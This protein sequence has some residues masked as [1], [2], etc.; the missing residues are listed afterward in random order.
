MKPRTQLY[1]EDVVEGSEIPTGFSLKITWT[2]IAKNV[3]GSQDFYA[4]HHDPDFARAHGHRDPFVMRGF[5]NGCFNRL[6]HDWMGDEGFLRKFHMEF[7]KSNYLA[8]TITL[9]GKV[10]R[11]HMDNSDH[12]V[13][14][15][16]WCENEKDG[17]TT[18]CKCTVVLPSRDC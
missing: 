10:T 11:K 6:I 13:D 4:V 14:A 3:S 17:I 1:W 16:I 8:D 2:Q 7:R 9:K 12:C 5:M 18:P 15:D